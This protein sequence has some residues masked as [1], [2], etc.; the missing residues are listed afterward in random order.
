[1]LKEIPRNA[2]TSTLP[3]RYVLCTSTASM[4]TAIQTIDITRSPTC[5][6]TSTRG[7]PLQWLVRDCRPDRRLSFQRR[8]SS[9]AE[10]PAVLPTL[11][12]YCKC[13]GKDKFESH[14]R[15]SGHARRPEV[16]RYKTARCK[17]PSRC[18]S[19]TWLS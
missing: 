4:R 9:G 13:S 16:S 7:I 11:L 12:K 1:M 10:G 15:L 14:H 2:G 5:Q 18:V 19:R 6:Q 8:M 17:I 3:T